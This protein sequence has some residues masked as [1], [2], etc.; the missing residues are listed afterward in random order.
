MWYFRRQK[1]KWEGMRRNRPARRAGTLLLAA[2]M[3]GAALT[4]AQSTPSGAAEID[5]A[6]IDSAE[7]D[8]VVVDGQNPKATWKGRGTPQPAHHPSGP[9]DVGGL[10]VDGC[11]EKTVQVNVDPLHWANVGGALE[12]RL[13][14]TGCSALRDPADFNLYVYQGGALIGSSTAPASIADEVVNIGSPSGNY[15]VRVVTTAFLTPGLPT[16]EVEVTLGEGAKYAAM[17]MGLTCSESGTWLTG[18]AWNDELAKAKE[19]NRQVKPQIP[20]DSCSGFVRRPG[21]P[22]LYVNISL[23]TG[24]RG[25]LPTVALLHGWSGTGGDWRPVTVDG[26]YKEGDTQC[27]PGSYH[28]N[29]PWYVTRG[30]AAISY[31][32]RG[33]GSSCGFDQ[34]PAVPP[35]ECT[36]GWTQIAHRSAEVADTKHL[37][38]VAVDAGVSHRDRLGASGGSYGGGQSWLLATELP[39]KTPKG[40]ELQLAAAAPAYGWTSLQN[41][42]AP[43][44]R[45]TDAATQ[46]PEGLDAPYGVVKQGLIHSLLIDSRK[47]GG[48]DLLCGWAPVCPRRFMRFNDTHPTQLHSHVAS[49]LAFWEAGEPYQPGSSAFTAAFREK[50]AYHAEDYLRQL[51]DRDVKP[52]PIFAV[53]G[54]TDALF[55][56]VEAL[57]MYRRLKQAHPGYPIWTTFDNAGHGSRSDLQTRLAND[58]R[59]AF[60]DRYLR[61]DDIDLGPKVVSLRSSCGKDA[62]DTTGVSAPNWDAIRG[63]EITLSE[64]DPLLSQRITTHAGRPGQVAGA[65]SD[66]IGLACTTAGTSPPGAAA[67]WKWQAPTAGMTLLGLPTVSVDYALTGVDATLVGKMWDIAPDGTRILVTRG[68]YRLTDLAPVSSGRVSFQLDGNHWQ[69][70]AGHSIELELTQ[71]D[72]PMFQADNLPSRLVLSKP[73]VRL[74]TPRRG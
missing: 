11:S 3:V 45:A 63:P 48:V 18:K 31:S 34:D 68:A 35:Q 7:I 47:G 51:A 58:R 43:N 54:W 55:P 10:G 41:S 29:S 12:V 32:A 8:A 27:P 4:G 26:C 70:P 19:E 16:Y 6:E 44:G 73:S 49:W 23:P 21:A 46:T 37:L 72:A 9:C 53:Q 64:S 20:F 67:S 59:T 39:W 14:T 56:A 52:V 62:P 65:G 17:G 74:P 2:S 69:V 66:G 15:V 61:G 22:P 28:N 42:L 5:A 13:C 33:H 30:Y 24:A 71:S 1:P 36:E 57:Q 40:T 60:F 25:P 50:S 38:S